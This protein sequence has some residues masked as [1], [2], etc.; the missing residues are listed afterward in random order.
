MTRRTAVASC[1][2]LM[3]S[4]TAGVG[5]QDYPLTPVPPALVTK[6]V[7][8]A[9]I[10]E[11][12]ANPDLQGDAKPKLIAL[13][14]KALSN[15]QEVETHRARAD[16]FEELTRAAP[17]QTQRLR[18][19]KAATT[20]ADAPRTLGVG[21]DT[22]IDQIESQLK[23]AQADRAAEDARR[24]EF[25][26]QLTYQKSRPAAIR[27]RLTAAQEEQEAIAAALQA[28]PAGDRSAAI[29]SP[30]DAGPSFGPSSALMEAKRWG[31]ETRY[32]ALST[33]IKALDQEL[34]GLPL[35]LD[36][37]AARRDAESAGDGSI[38]QR[39][40]GLRALAGARRVLDAKQA[41]A[42][43]DRLVQATAHLDPALARLAEQN[44]ALIAEFNA[45]AEQGDRLDA[46]KQDAERLTTRTQASFER[47]QTAKVVGVP[48]EGLGS[49]LL[50]HRA[51][52]PD[53][54]LYARRARDLGQQIA[55]V[56]LSRLRHQEA[57][58]Q[59][60]DHALAGRGG[61]SQDIESQL[62]EQ[63]RD[64]LGKLL[65][66]EARHLECLRT[67]R[68]AQARMLEAARTYGAFLNEE[69]FWLPTAPK[70]RLEELGKL[71]E[72]LRALVS[73]DRWSELAPAL[74]GGVVASPAFWLAL[75]LS[76][77]LVWRR[78]ALIAAIQ[79]TAVPLVNPST[80]RFR[81][82]IKALL[83]TLAL[84]APLPLVLGTLGWRLMD[85][86][87]GS[88]I[89]LGV[90]GY[91][92]RTALI[93][94]VLLALRALCLPGGLG[95]GH[96]RWAESD[97]RQF[98][99]ELRWLTW[100][101][102]PTLLVVYI[103]MGLEPVAAGG[104]VARVGGWIAVLLLGLFF[105][106]LLNPRHGVLRRQRQAA[107]P[108]LL[109]RAYW[110]W[111]PLLLA[112]PL[113][114]L[115]LAWSG[116][117]Y[118]ARILADAFLITLGLIAAL[119]VVHALGVRWLNLTRRRLALRA[120]LQRR[121]AA[122]VAR[123]QGPSQGA[124]TP[125]LT[126][127]DAADLD[128]EA[129]STGSLELLGSA[130]AFVAAVGLYLIWSAVFPALGV[131]Q[132]V[133]L[134]HSTLILDGEERHLPITLAD[135]G[136][137]LV[138]LGAMAVLAKRLP[139]LLNMILAQR[140]RLTSGSRY[141]IT[142][143][144]TYAIVAI[145]TLL[146]LN[147]I[148]AR[149]SQLQWLVAALGVGIGFGLQEIV[150]NFIS[151]LII[152]FERPIRIGDVVTVGT[153]DGV[154]TKIRIRATTIRNWDRKELLVPNKEFITGRLLNWSLSDQ[155]TRVM[156]TVGVAYGT[157][158]EQAHALMR[159]AAEEHERVLKDPE[160]TLSFEGF[161]DNSLTLILRAFID[162][163]DY[164][165][166]TIT[167]LHKAIYQKFQQAGIGI[168]FPQRDLHL[169]TREPLRVSLEGGHPDRPEGGTSRPA[170]QD[171]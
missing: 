43:A 71:P 85:A 122:V 163:L 93:L 155:V 159:E 89:S 58:E 92:V 34:I 94:Y 118:T 12:E 42:E 23:Q 60:A 116:Y 98:D 83:L 121:Q 29:A 99:H 149:W 164:R 168:A 26:R 51:V 120:A 69:L 59:L 109:H 49:L 123:E 13:Y 134:W 112:F 80:D 166:A 161:G 30:P 78:G 97:V 17:E 56:N 52:L 153:T 125:D 136:L 32:I 46:E 47:M 16:A 91:L 104:P 10:S 157:D 4:L 15:L 108:G 147:A 3:A 101:L 67:L 62:T 75:L 117:I 130:T 138:Y 126:P 82:T 72:E 115:P 114:M 5:A 76:V 107:D 110:L 38:E 45:I 106:R 14:R 77:V 2:L 37:I 24:A 36:L 65:E 124:E 57:R 48:T 50:E 35:R 102:V 53:A 6:P 28:E 55:V 148:G 44:A 18:E 63:R 143:L 165:V 111:F 7:V 158:V 131:L 160:P 152:L 95:I 88:N 171:L 105:Y 66:A 90:G 86:T 150:A 21:L 79:G 167:D 25:E 113:L 129:A 54:G 40:E 74:R 119:M 81:Y 39:V 68:T 22:P 87:Q 132:D 96:F 170:S 73:A 11:A 137:A 154:V 139:A 151:G 70:R 27:Q 8:E 142:T 146:A 162:D 64:L 145:G 20:Q 31:L 133:V 61:A 19:R 169:D 144:T 127:D 103:A 100:T 141:T 84:A 33:E 135:L 128:L 140:S 156:V 41:G 1:L 9:R